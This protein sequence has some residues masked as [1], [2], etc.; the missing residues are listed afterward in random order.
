MEEESLTEIQQFENNRL[1]E[2]KSLAGY[3]FNP[4]PHKFPVTLS[5]QDYIEKYNHI[6]TGSRHKELVE[7]IAG[8]V[9]EKRG[10]GKKLAF[11]TVKSNEHTLQYLADKKEYEN[12]DNFTNINNLIHRGD[13]VGAR[14]FVGKSLKGELS[15]Y[16]LELVLLSP[17]YKYLPKQFQGIVDI[18]IRMKNRHLDMIANP[19]VIQTFKIR[20]KVIREIRKFLEDMDFIELQTPVLSNHAGGASAKPFVTKHNDL[21]QKMYLRI[22]PELYLKKLVIG[23]IDR[24]YEIGPQ[25]RNEKCDGTHNAEFQSLEF[26]MAYAD[27][28]DLFQICEDMLSNIVM[29]IHNGYQVNYLPMHKT[30]EITIDFTPPY[31]KIDIM[32]ELTNLT[33]ATFPKDLTTEDARLFLD[34]L[35]QDLNVDCSNP[36]TASRLI[37]KLIGHYLEPQCINPTFLMN[38]PLVMSPLAKQH[39][40]DPNLTERFELFVCGMELANAYTELNNHITQI[41][42][43]T[44]QQVER[45]QGDDE[46]Q[47]IDEGFVDALRYGLP[48]CCGFGCGIDR[49]VMFLT[50]NNSIREVIPFPATH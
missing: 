28:N 19:K 12:E 40:S 45:F 24:V 15:I 35:C 5:F 3:G 11:Y 22:A 29:K 37:D 10:N 26:Y 6:E 18:D 20:S 47:S 23:G 42:R 46:A 49:I 32:S 9:L 36:R 34:Q 31:K 41:E 14:G 33:G 7:C 43:F 48:P 38:H 13:I 1:A 8:R 27:Y 21:D 2:F 25:F 50:N 39:R 44:Y 17:C 16:P 4:Y 30:E